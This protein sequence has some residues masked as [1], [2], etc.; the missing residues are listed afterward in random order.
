MSSSTSQNSTTPAS[1]QKQA[2]SGPL[3][4][5]P[6]TTGR[7]NREGAVLGM[8]GSF[9]LDPS[10]PVPQPGPQRLRPAVAAAAA[11][12]AKVEQAGLLSPSIVVESD[13]EKTDDGLL[14][15]GSCDA[16]ARPVDL[17]LLRSGSWTH[18]KFERP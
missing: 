1:S 4:S 15:W 8:L 7:L 14:A 2:L 10:E 3:S 16:D 13:L 5:H 17:G 6:V 18:E 12:A 9:S 11:A